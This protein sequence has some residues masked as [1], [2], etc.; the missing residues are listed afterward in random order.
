MFDTTRPRSIR[1]RLTLW[2]AVI[3]AAALGLFGSLIWL[4]L[5]NRLISELDEDL[6][7][8]ASRFENYFKSESLEAAEGQL[9]GEL[10]EFCQAL[11]S[12]SYISVR[13]Q[14]GFMFRYPAAAATP[15]P[16]FRML[17]SR[18]TSAGETLDLE[19]ATPMAEVAH[20]LG[21]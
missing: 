8:S 9:R 17:R 7:A 1:F 21:L 12:S 6:A 2:Y 5:R 14:S 16:D 18:F 4:S 19:V 11:P 3:L 13:G 10:E 15:G 20:T